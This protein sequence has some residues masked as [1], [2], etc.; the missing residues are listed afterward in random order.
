[1]SFEIIYDKQFIVAEKD[2]KKFYIP[3]LYWGSNNCIQFDRSNRG[4]RER[5]WSVFSWIAGGKQFATAETMLA[6]LAEEEAKLHEYKKDEH[7]PDPAKSYGYYTS[8]QI[9]TSTRTTTFAMYKGLILT[10]IRKALTVEQL[11][12]EHVQVEVEPYAYR[13]EETKAKMAEQG[14]PWLGTQ[15]A[16]STEHLMELLKLYSDTYDGKFGW[17]V[18]FSWD[19]ERRMKWLRRRYF[20][21]QKGKQEYEYQTVDNYFSVQAKQL[22]GD[23]WYW[24][25]KKIRYGFKYTYSPYHKFATEKEA[26]Q[27]ANRYKGRVLLR[28]QPVNERTQV[29]VLKKKLV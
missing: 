6:K 8:I 9:G 7:D 14:L 13:I 19:I 25:M 4:R 27:F 5:N 18:G 28:V 24:F 1:M 11:A 3:M 20:P 12:V 26:Q 17:H 15:T 2:T 22:T 29:K 23:S 21:T 10:G 16:T